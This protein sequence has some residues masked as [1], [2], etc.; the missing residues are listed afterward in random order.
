MARIEFTIKA[1][2]EIIKKRGLHKYGAVQR[3][4][5]GEALSR[6]EPYTP[7]KSGALIESGRST[8]KIGSGK[9]CYSAPYARVQHGGVSKSGKAMKYSGAPLRG[10]YW[11]E[12]MKADNLPSILA[13]A[14][15]EAGA[16][17]TR[18]GGRSGNASV[19][20]SQPVKTVLGKRRNPV[21]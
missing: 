13:L 8:T 19:P 7:K 17:G 3:L 9:I 4:I 6:C 15:G 16:S 12:R 2:L 5:D 21:F 18:A 1:P 20:K 10:A 14:A 11:F